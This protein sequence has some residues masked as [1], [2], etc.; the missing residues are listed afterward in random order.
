ME[1][2]MR[3][4][5]RVARTTHL[6]IVVALALGVLA[7][8]LTHAAPAPGLPPIVFVA[9]AHL[10]SQ[11]YI[12]R[13]ELGPP[14]QLTTGIDKFAP[15]SKLMVRDA[16]GTLRLLLDTARP[17]GDE[18][19]PLGLRDLA[20]PDVS[21]DGRRIVFAGTTGPTLPN[22]SAAAQPRFQWRLY[23]LA[24]A[25]VRQL[26]YSDRAIHIPYGLG[27][28][29][30]Y[31]WYDDMFPAYLADG[32]IVFSSSRYPSRA[33]YDGRPS[34]NLY[35]IDGDGSNMRR[36]TN[37][38]GGALHPTP[39]PDGR[40]LFSRW[41]VNF[42]QPS[43]RDVYSRI[44]NGA[45]SEVARD[46]AGN[47]IAVQRDVTV[48]VAG[49]R[50]TP[51]GQAQAAPQPP[52][53]TPTPWRPSSVEHLDPATGNVY[54]VTVTPLP[55]Q[56][57]PRATP[58]PTARPQPS[59]QPASGASTRTVTVSVPVTGHRLP[60]G[61]L[62]YS[63]TE[64]TFRPARGRLPDG[65]FIPDAPNTWHL[66]SI[67]ADGSDMRR[68]AWTPRYLAQLADD[69]GNDTFNAAQPALVFK[70]G[71]TLVAYTTQRDG[72]MAHTSLLTGIR[73]ARPG[74]AAMG[75]NAV[76]SI[77]GMRWDGSASTGYALAPAGLP[78]GR[79]VFSQSADDPQAVQRGTYRFTQ[80]GRSFSIALQ[81]SALRWSLQLANVDG[82][83]AQALPFEERLPGFDLLDATPIVRRLVGA[84]PGAWQVPLE[85]LCVQGC[86]PPAV[87]DPIGWNVPAGLRTGEG[88]P[89]Y[90]WSQRPISSVQ[91]TVLHNANVY[92]NAPLELPY[93]NNSPALGSVAFADIY[94][95]A[96]QFS[97]ASYRA[98]APDDQV[99]AVKWLTVP[100]APDGSFTA[101]APAD[102][103]V[104]IVLRDKEGRV[105]RGGN[106]GSIRIAQGNTSGRPNQVVTCVGCHMGHAS[107]SLD[108]QPLA[109]LGWSNVAPSAR[110]TASSGQANASHL[111]DRRGYVASTVKPGAF[112]DTTPS[113]VATGGTGEQV[114]LNW[115]LPIAVLQV[116][117]V[118]PEP[119][120][121]GFSSEYRVSGELRF[122]LAGKELENSRQAVEAVAPLS[123]NGS[124]VRLARPVAADRVVFVVTSVQGTRNGRQA[125]AA[126]AEIE[127]IGQGASPAVLNTQPAQIALP[128][129]G[130]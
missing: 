81:G 91:L 15:G 92:A 42:N 35:V 28:A 26:T 124:S 75:E 1:K 27:N 95:D 59:A 130:R 63:N 98:D 51:A 94:L 125:P 41:W 78:D 54:R 104:F 110:V 24:G 50:Q 37:E 121:E 49:G 73:V 97:G 61:T 111:N 99:R 109:Q 76:E 96:N 56:P 126:L 9:R 38:R 114:E 122:F 72:T 8:R 88:K 129:M 120:R 5:H 60:D 19:N 11:D 47:V 116:R 64:T 12:F 7:T 55:P 69:D 58:R 93:V 46:A 127:V 103:P 90:S 18:L 106:R 25:Q 112:Q 123:R 32:R 108:G 20:S 21:F 36:I 79:I 53:P 43:E 118:G 45:G 86:P 84:G 14:G 48:A 100:V 102:A 22:N 105:V 6:V 77:A 87:D 3:L 4:A 71:E 17:A 31:G 113:W 67:N 128:G 101:S 117:L 40:I 57:T 13:N 44:D 34:F 66:M 62:V 80:N 107:G 82:S 52:P 33:H 23:E 74:A 68:Y 85:P 65:T 115:D 83:G 119:G 70:D 2:V 10:A 89:A 30:A 29:D 39:L 16:D